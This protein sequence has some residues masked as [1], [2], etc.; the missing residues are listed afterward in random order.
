M[1][2]LVPLVLVSLLAGVLAGCGQA[3]P[4]GTATAV[5]TDTVSWPAGLFAAALPDGAVALV[6]AKD[7]ARPGDRVVFEARVGGRKDAFVENRAVFFVADTSLPTCADLHGD[8]CKTPWDYCC[9]PA[10]NLLR[11]MATV[12]VVDAEGQPLRATLQDQHGLAHMKTVFVTGTVDAIDD[13]GNL[14]VNAETIHV[15]EQG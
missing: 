2:P 12:Q 6:E 10:E 11:H 8:S 15:R 14:V 7:A 9:E 3:S 5:P 4:S 13:A 1:R